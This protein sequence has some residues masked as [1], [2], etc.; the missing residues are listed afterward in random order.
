MD[1]LNYPLIIKFNTH[2]VP[3]FK[4]QKGK[5]YVLFGTDNA[6]PEYILKLYNRSAKHNAI[7]NSKA[8]YIL[9][10]GWSFDELGVDAV[11]KSKMQLF[12]NGFEEPL[13]DLTRKIILDYELFGGFALEVTW[14]KD[15]KKIA[16]LAHVD[17][18]YVRSNQDNTEFY[19]TKNWYKKSGESFLKT[20]T[21]EDSEDFTV[22]KPYGEDDKK[23][24]QLLY[25]KMYRPSLDV[26]PLPEYL[27]A[28]VAIETDIE[29][30]NY[31]YNNLKNGFTATVLIN[32]NNGVPTDEEKKKI[33][34]EIETKLS[35]SDNAGKFI[36]S[37]GDGKDK[38]A[39]VIV[40]NMS[41]AHTMFEQL[42]KDTMQEMFVG[43]RITSPMLMGVRVE[44][45][46]GGRTE[47][48]EANELF[49]A[50]Y[51]NPKQ[52]IFERIFNEFADI[53]GL[54]PNLKLTK[55]SPIGLDW[56]GNTDLFNL[57]TD[58]EKREKAGLK[59]VKGTQDTLT[60][61]N[62]I[63]PLVANKVIESMSV[64]EIR[65]LVG[66]GATTGIQRTTVTE[67]SQ[68]GKIKEVLQN[69][70]QPREKFKILKSYY[71]KYTSGKELFEA[72]KDLMK[73]HFAL[74]IEYKTLEKSIIDL[75]SKN[76]EMTAEQ[77]AD[78]TNSTVKKVQSTIDKLIDTKILKPSTKGEIEVIKPTTRGQDIIEEQPAK[79]IDI[80]I[81]YS[82]EK[83]DGVK[84]NP[85]LPTT[86]DFCKDTYEATQKKLYSF[87]E[88]N[89]L[90]NGTDLDVWLSGG[91]FWNNNGKIEPHCRHQWV[92]HVVEEIT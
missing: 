51:V 24:P 1:K 12:I 5:D 86:R 89:S 23:K 43:H 36:L 87:D 28:N 59:N 29:I 61:L 67:S 32:F 41:D 63:S 33:Q 57:L 19:Y 92:Q 17:F 60:A 46:L 22:Y 7:I 25:Y 3:E 76:P 82:Y 68:F 78:V 72:E 20:N 44:G 13:N 14:S 30:N 81:K 15:G 45:Q 9:G 39:E 85:I 71:P 48:I 56:F 55:S 6:Y 21:P 26:Y 27:G 64:N 40:L 18:T 53:N 91:G 80:F 70:G 8:N 54:R 35:G 74:E 84:G 4:E 34:K 62:S 88:I 66:L 49:Q 75:L 42:R 37:F 11:Q 16:G 65:A 50:T 69:F 79:T 47:M 83:I 31:H 10:N 38:S 2:K 90:N 73:Q 58:E 77:I 52:K